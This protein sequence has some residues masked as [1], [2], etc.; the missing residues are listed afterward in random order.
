MPPVIRLTPVKSS[1]NVVA[2]FEV[3]FQ[4]FPAP[5]GMEISFFEVDTNDSLMN[6]TRKQLIGKV[7]GEFAILMDQKPKPPLLGLVPRQ[8]ATTSSGAKRISF[9]FPQPM[10]A[11]PIEFIF[12]LPTDA[13]DRF[14]GDFWEIQ[15]VGDDPAKTESYTIP[16]ARVIRALPSRP[17][18]ATYPWSAGNQVQLYHDASSVAGGGAGAFSDLDKAIDDAQHFIF[19]ADWSFHAHM[20]LSQTLGTAV[21]DTVGAKLIRKA[22]DND[23]ILIAIHTWDHTNAGAPDGQNDFGDTH[24]ENITQ[25]LFKAPRPKNLRWRAS[26]RTGVGFSHH[27]KFVVLDTPAK[28]GRRTIKVFF[29]GLDLT[30]GRFDWGDHLIL[31]GDPGGGGF[32]STVAY[33]RIGPHVF[34][35]WYNAEFFPDDDSENGGNLKNTDQT[36]PRQPWHDIHAQLTGPAA[37]DVVREFVGRWNLDPSSVDAMGDDSDDDIQMILDRFLELFNKKV[38]GKETRLFVQQWEHGSGPW[39]AQV[40]R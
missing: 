16:I 5:G 28:D 23:K 24:L 27:Q 11:V 1:Q 3:T 29:G 17:G 14:E 2:T 35:D 37:W 22:R 13:A 30:K 8:P 9:V 12:D 31:A 40:Y 15:A 18:L 10:P 7:L 25:L 32:T 33:T 36:L 4:G 34:N 19:V 26:S 39:V 6:Q 38:N 20:R 21:S